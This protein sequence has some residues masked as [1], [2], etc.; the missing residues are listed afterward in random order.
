MM[1]III[2]IRITFVSV[3]IVSV[4]YILFRCDE[5]DMRKLLSVKFNVYIKMIK[6]LSQSE[7]NNN[8]NIYY[9]DVYIN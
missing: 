4:L 7:N 2:I 5:E 6:L 8:A 1:I 9:I 3:N